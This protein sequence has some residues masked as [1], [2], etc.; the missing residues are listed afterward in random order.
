MGQSQTEAITNLQTPIPN[1]FNCK[2]LTGTLH[3]KNSIIINS[4]TEHR[5][6]AF[7]T[8]ANSM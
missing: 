1:G 7:N 2:G 5:Q 3:R 4:L 8:A 6:L